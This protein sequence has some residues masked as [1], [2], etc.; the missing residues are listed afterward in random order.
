MTGAE[1]RAGT[2]SWAKDD[3]VGPFYPPGLASDGHLEHYA[4]SFDTVEVDATYYRTPRREFCRAWREKTPA[5][6]RFSLK[7]M[8]RVTQDKVLADCGRE[9][10]YFLGAVGELG[11][12]F[13]FAVLQFSAFGKKSRCPDLA[14]F[15]QRL[16]D[17]APLCPDPGKFVVEIRN[18]EWLNDELLAFLREHRFVF[19]LNEVERMPRPAEA[20]ERFGERLVTGGAAYARIFGERK[21]IEAMTEKYDRILLDRTEETRTWVGICRTLAAKGVPVWTYFSNYFAGYAPGSVELF[22]QLLAHPA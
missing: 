4:R 17:F 5:N 18:P 1:I 9:M 13:G 15:L 12:K 14:T 10:E 7:V 6:F 2:V 20:W 21:K 19:A 16:R 3:W 22:R 11:E 8:K